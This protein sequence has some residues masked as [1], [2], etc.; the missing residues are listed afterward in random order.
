M[1]QLFTSSGQ[2]IGVLASEPVLPMNIQGWFPLRL[3]GLISLQAK[4]LSRVFSSTT[5]WKH[6]FFSTQLS[7][8]SNFHICTWLQ[9]EGGR[10]RGR[11]RMRWLDSITSSMD[12]SLSKF[13]ELVMDREAWRVTVHGVA[14][15]WTRLS[16]LNWNWTETRDFLPCLSY[17]NWVFCCLQPKEF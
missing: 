11:Q 17:P 14:K 10:R 9:I 2:S 7:L 6:Q 1:N 12:M 5:D 15:S 13:W 8:W 3:I 16:E 4:G